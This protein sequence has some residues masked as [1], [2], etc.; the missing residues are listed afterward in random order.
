[1]PIRTDRNSLD[2]R[3]GVIDEACASLRRPEIDPGGEVIEQK[4][5]QR[6]RTVEAA[7][8]RSSAFRPDEAVG[9][10][11]F[12]E[13][14]EQRLAAGL[15]RWKRVLRRAPCRA[16]ARLVAVEAEHNVVDGAKQALNVCLGR[17]GAEGRYRVVDARLRQR[18][19]VHVAL[20]HQQPHRRSSRAPCAPQPVEFAA[21]LKHRR[22]R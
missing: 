10:L 22:L 3:A 2:M 5:A 7:L 14:E 20:H 18:H 12:G 11:A 9:I 17:G 15:H 19:Y 13:E 8:E 21:L 4:P 6:H 1:M 16:P